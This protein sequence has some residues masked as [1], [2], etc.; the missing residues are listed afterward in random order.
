VIS[1]LRALVEH[2]A[3]NPQAMP[4]SFMAERGGREDSLRAAV[5]WVSGM[6][7]RFACDRAVE[8]LG[9]PEDRLPRGIDV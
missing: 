7:D 5:A 4:E 8:L 3:G 6:T 2:Y 1:V 9:W